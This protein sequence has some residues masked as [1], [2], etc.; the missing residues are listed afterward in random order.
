MS[1][2]R[3]IKVVGPAGVGKAT[4]IGCMLFKYGGIPMDVMEVFQRDGITKYDQVPAKL[5]ALK[6]VPTFDI[7]KY[8]VIILDSSSDKKADCTILVISPDKLLGNAN[9][10]MKSMMAIQESDRIIILL[11]KMDMYDWSEA[12]FRRSKKEILDYLI[13]LGKDI[14]RVFIV[15]VSSTG[16]D[17]YIG[18]SLKSSWYVENSKPSATVLDA[19]TSVLA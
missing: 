14:T 12:Q 2:A 19:L 7:P 17:N 5:A 15:P 16:G 9:C 10:D 4:S 3:S 13:S 1:F 6:V 11:N 8:H 18:T